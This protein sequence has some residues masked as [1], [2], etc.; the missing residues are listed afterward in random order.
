MGSV[1]G[2]VKD[3]ALKCNREAVKHFKQRKDQIQ[4]KFYKIILTALWNRM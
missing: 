1:V 4:R 2:H 3:S